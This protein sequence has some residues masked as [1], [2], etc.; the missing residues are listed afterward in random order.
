M[1][2][3]TFSL[4]AALL[5]GNTAASAAAPPANEMPLQNRIEAAQTKINNLIGEQPDTTAKSGSDRLAQHHWNDH[6]WGDHHRRR[7]YDRDYGRDDH[8]WRDHHH[9][10]WRDWDDH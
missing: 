3:N 10:R 6:R 4:I 5:L 7:D 1:A 8:H 9:R 2:R